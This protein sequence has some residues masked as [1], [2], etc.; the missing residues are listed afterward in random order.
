MSKTAMSS[1][2]TL[3]DDP[4]FAAIEKHRK[5]FFEC[6][7]Y[8]TDENIV[9]LSHIEKE[10]LYALLDERPTTFAG[11]AALSGYSAELTALFGR[12]GW[13]R[14]VTHPDD[15]RKSVAW[16]Y[17]VHRHVADAVSKLTAAA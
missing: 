4:I 1:R 10:A 15:E 2:K 9:R 11:V 7:E 3:A 14:P 8:G 17:Y 13:S 12:T 6:E 5:A 16:S